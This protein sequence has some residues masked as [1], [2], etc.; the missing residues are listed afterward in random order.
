MTRGIGWFDAF[1]EV[2]PEWAVVV[3]GLVTQLGDVWFLGVLVG[4]S[5]WLETDNRDRIAAVFGVLLA[6]L[7]L[8]TALKHVFALPRPERT[9]VAAEAL[10]EAVHPLYEATA[11]ATGYGFPSGHALLTTIVYLSLA[12]Y[13]SVGT[14][15]NRYIGAAGIVTVVCFSRVGL[16]VHYLVDVIA[17]VGI[18]LVF[19]LLVWRLLDRYPARRGTLGFGLAVALAAVAFVTTD[20]ASDAVLL[21]GASVG[22]FAGWQFAALVRE[23]DAGRGPIRGSRALTARAAAVAAGVVSLVALSGYY[24]PVSSL[25]GSGVLGL[26]VAAFVTLPVLYRSERGSG[27]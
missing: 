20:A 15:R 27:I 3:L 8:I 16:G 10:P 25:A 2:A 7:S 1:R 23:V 19:L 17:G 13:G 6:G 21:V 9:L 11:T 12:E 24:W 5:Y 4:T 22:A 26:V 18:G 14:R